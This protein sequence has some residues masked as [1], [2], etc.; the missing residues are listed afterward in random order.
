MTR[1]RSRGL[2]VLASV[3]ATACKPGAGDPCDAGKSHACS[4]DLVCADPTNAGARC[5]SVAEASKRCATTDP[6]KFSGACAF[7][8]AIEMCVPGSADDCKQSTQ[9][10]YQGECALEG[11]SCIVAFEADCKQSTV[12]AKEGKCALGSTNGYNACIAK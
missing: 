3:L 5:L 10:K 8:Q 7:S 6:C 9:C 12:C 4:G 1:H 2:I 11:H